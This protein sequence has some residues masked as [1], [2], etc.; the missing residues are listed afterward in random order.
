MLRLWDLLT[1][2]FSCR[3]SEALLWAVAMVLSINLK[4]EICVAEDVE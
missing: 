2:L 1:H 4:S 3:T